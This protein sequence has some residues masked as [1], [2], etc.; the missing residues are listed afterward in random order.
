MCDDEKV[1]ELLQR[2][3]QKLNGM[4]SSLASI[5]LEVMDISSI[6]GHA[7]TIEDDVGDIKKILT[8]RD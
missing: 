4:E 2:I 8:E 1:I 5:N 3:L 7:S 6:E